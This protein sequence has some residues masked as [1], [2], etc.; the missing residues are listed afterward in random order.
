MHQSKYHGCESNGRVGRQKAAKASVE[1]VLQEELLVQRPEHVAADVRKIGRV[2][3][4]KR[5]RVFRRFH[6]EYAQCNGGREDPKRGGE[7]AA[8]QAQ[9]VHPGAAP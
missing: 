8:A 4:V 7:S 5:S 2:E 1:E 9:F 3:R 6:S